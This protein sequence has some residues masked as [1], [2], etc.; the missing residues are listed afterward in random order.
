MS[1][2]ERLCIR[3]F[4]WNRYI[5][6]CSVQRSVQCC[7]ISWM[8][9]VW[10][11]V[12]FCRHCHSNYPGTTFKLPWRNIVWKITNYIQATKE[13]IIRPSY[14]ILMFIC[15]LKLH[16]QLKFRKI[17]FV[18]KIHF[19][20]SIPIF[21]EVVCTEH[22][23]RPPGGY[24]ISPKPILNSNL[25]KTCLSTTFIL[26]VQSFCNFVQGTAVSMPCSVQNWKKIRQLV[27]SQRGGWS[28]QSHWFGTPE[29]AFIS[30]TKSEADAGEGVGGN[31]S[32]TWL[33]R[34]SVCKY[35]SSI[36]IIIFMCHSF[37]IEYIIITLGRRKIYK[38]ISEKLKLNSK[39][40]G[41]YI[42][43]DSAEG[44]YANLSVGKC[45]WIQTTKALTS[46]MTCHVSRIHM[47]AI[48]RKQQSSFCY[49]TPTPLHPYSITV[50]S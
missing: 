22:P 13:L 43:Y 28:N 21:L 7:L 30:S 48:M 25:V 24:C 46:A 2:Y 40:R 18:H 9:T 45:N 42:C 36:R 1:C 33:N 17:S 26:F 20:S 29:F 27:M 47:I 23:G 3:Y 14:P 38:F 8:R 35:L 49:L 34:S 15:I 5:R 50:T 37:F 10:L 4:R 19:S 44:K 32:D 39:Y 12:R 6:I 31:N 41:P 11:L 16:L